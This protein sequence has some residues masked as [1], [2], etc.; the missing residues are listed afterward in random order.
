MFHV[1]DQGRLQRGVNEFI[2]AESSEQRVRAHAGN[3]AGAAAE[4]SGLW[5]TEQLVSAIGDD[6][7]SAAQAVE[8][9]AL[10]AN[11]EMREIDE[12]SAAQILHQR[13]VFLAGQI[14][15]FRG[16]WL[17][18][19]TCDFEIR[20]MHAKQ[21]PRAI[22]DRVLV[23]GDTCPFVVPTSRRIAP[24]FAIT[25]GIRNDPP[26][27]TSSPR[28]TMTSPPSAR[29]LSASSTAAALLFTTM[30]AISTPSYALGQQLFE[31]AINVDVA[32]APFSGIDIELQ[33][34]VAGGSF[35]DVLE[36]GF[37]QRRASEIG[38]QNDTGGIDDRPQRVAERCR[39]TRA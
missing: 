15:Q 10:S 36:R 21:Q 6:V 39:A 31:Q 14:D 34:A 20:A 12:R 2:D 1:R 27:S 19:E 11:A 29:E 4:Q 3:Q 30:V 5:S 35:A 28:E 22:I 8:N 16:R 18:G 32:L 7:D 33:I 23:V 13:D 25:S 9:A 37:T 17:L 38:M 26:I 24:D